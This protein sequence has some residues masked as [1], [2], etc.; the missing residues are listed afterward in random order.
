MAQEKVK[1]VEEIYRA[2]AEGRSA[3]PL[4]EEDLEYVNP[5]EAVEQGTK[6]GRHYL[7]KIRDAYPELEV[8]A[9]RVIDAG[10]EDVVVIAKFRGRARASG[11]EMEWKQGYVWSIRNGKAIRFRWFSDPRDAFAAVGLPDAGAE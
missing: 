11:V 8:E 9:E 10:G 4:I 7:G 5:P 6:R 3:A 1:I 2:W